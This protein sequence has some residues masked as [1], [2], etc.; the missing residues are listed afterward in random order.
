MSG[1]DVGVQWLKRAA[2]A[3]ASAAGKFEEAASLYER[4]LWHQLTG[5]IE[6]IVG[7]QSIPS[8]L[9]ISLYNDFIALFFDRLNALKLAQIA[10]VASRAFTVLSEKEG[11]LKSAVEQI[12]EEAKRQPRDFGPSATEA[13]LYIGAHLAFVA[14]TEGRQMDC[15]V[16]IESAF[17]TLDS[18][19]D[20]DPSVS[21]AVHYS[22][23]Q[24]AK[25]RKDY[26][27]FFRAGLL[28]LAYIEVESLSSDVK[29]GL[30][31][32]LGLSALLG[33]SIY[34]F[35]E[36]LQHPIV[37]AL[38]GTNF[39]WLH[40]MLK[41]FNS[42]DLTKY[43]ELCSV[44]AASLNAQPALVAEATALREKITILCLMQ[45]IFKLPSEDRVISLSTITEQTKLTIEGVEMLLMR[46]L[47]AKL[48]EGIID[49]VA[50]TVSITW[51]QPRVLTK[52]EVRELHNRLDGWLKKVHIALDT[53][54][55]QVPTQVLAR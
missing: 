25:A 54:E 36:L 37:L 31:V 28:Y 11:F 44:H 17:E 3:H 53:V 42:G 48:I 18:M 30:A 10:V 40:S 51:V 34:N 46:A 15:K 2:E 7:D 4:K 33:K 19:S 50:G 12:K 55:G 16:L 26:A 47:S 49:Q 52:P 41:I 27:G 39:E 8:A 5:V 14:L 38:D 35:G 45:L 6:T 13:D 20:V 9:L 22:A 23:S 29:L 24:L 1:D 21:A 43:D 32:D